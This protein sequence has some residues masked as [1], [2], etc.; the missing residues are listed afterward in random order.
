LSYL[1]VHVIGHDTILVLCLLDS[2]LS[3]HVCLYVHTTWPHLIS[4]WVALSLPW[5]CMS[6]S[7]SLD[8]SEV[9]RRRLNLPGGAG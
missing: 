1:H 8:Q 9:L 5:T 7:R 2:V 3:I 6:K 4:R